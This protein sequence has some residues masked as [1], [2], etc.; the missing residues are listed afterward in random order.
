MNS[1]YSNVTSLVDHFFSLT[2]LCFSNRWRT[3]TLSLCV[4]VSSFFLLIII[5]N[6]SSSHPSPYITLF[7]THQMWCQTMCLF[8]SSSSFILITGYFN[9]FIFLMRACIYFRSLEQKKSKLLF[10][11]VNSR[12]NESSY[13]L[14]SS[15][16]TPTT[17]RR[18]R[19]SFV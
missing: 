18:R 19:K 3:V 16:H 17:R 13:P 12:S 14:K 9:C 6:W 1:I 7:P 10:G 11:A 15:L 8:S 4:C 5:M 2:H